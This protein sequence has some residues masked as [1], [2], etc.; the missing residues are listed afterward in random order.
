LV[1]DS[2]G[3]DWETE[4]NKELDCAAGDPSTECTGRI[5]DIA[6]ESGDEAGKFDV[7]ELGAREALTDDTDTL[8]L[9]AVLTVDGV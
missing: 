1:I 2:I 3:A 6:D 8:R 4:D 9:D 7:D 5:C